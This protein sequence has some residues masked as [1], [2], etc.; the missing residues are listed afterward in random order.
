M[1]NHDQNKW[2]I[3]NI[4]VRIIAYPFCAAFI[5]A[6]IYILYITLDALNFISKKESF[7]GFGLAIFLILIPFL[8]LFYD[9][10][11]IFSKNGNDKESDILDDSL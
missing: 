5:F 8:Y 6:G 10:K 7:I 3:V 1:N 2:T 11:T 4:F 9:L